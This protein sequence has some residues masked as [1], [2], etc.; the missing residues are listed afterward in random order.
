MDYLDNDRLSGSYD[1]GMALAITT[2]A[3]EKRLV[4]QI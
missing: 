1:R 4:L 2:G 3:Y